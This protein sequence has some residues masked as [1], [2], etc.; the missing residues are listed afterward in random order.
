MEA[1]LE[2]RFFMGTTQ[3]RREHAWIN[4]PARTYNTIHGKRDKNEKDPNW[5]HWRMF[6]TKTIKKESLNDWIRRVAPPSIEHLLDPDY[7]FYTNAESISFIVSAFISYV[8]IYRI[9][10]SRDEIEPENMKL[11]EDLNHMYLL[12]LRHDLYDLPWRVDGTKL[13]PTEYHH[14]FNMIPG[15][16]N[17]PSIDVKGYHWMHPAV[18]P[19]SRKVEFFWNL[20][21]TKGSYVYD[22]ATSKMRM[23]GTTWQS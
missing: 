5:F 22:G 3:E 10:F 15:I 6:D 18:P 11:F 9:V 20:I 4:P 19:D 23:S 21:A 17:P 7:G 8:D 13:T 12:R 16:A 2:N 1:Y 14:L